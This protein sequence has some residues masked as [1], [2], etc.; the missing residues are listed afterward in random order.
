MPF[1]LKLALRYLFS[2][3]KGLVR[4]TSLIAI[5]GI[6]VGVA[7]LIIAQAVAT[8]FR[9][10]MQDK[11]LKNTA[12]ITIL[13]EGELKISNWNI[14]KRK[15]EEIENVEE[16]IPTSYESSVVSSDGISS[17]A[18]I[19]VLP[20]KDLQGNV[21][22][23]KAGTTEISVSIG[24]ELLEKLKLKVGDKADLL[25]LGK[26][27]TPKSSEVYV[28]NVLETGLYEYD[29]TWIHISQQHYLKLKDLNV[30]SPTAF[31]VSLKDIFQSGKTVE[32]I[33]KA[34]GKNFK[35]IGWQ[36][37]NKPLF[38]ALSLERKV[39]LA[40]ILLI[41]FI[42][43]LN[44][45]TTLA[46]LVNERKFDI[47]VLRTCGARTKSLIAIFLFEGL[48][49]SLAGIFFGVCLGIG[50]CLLGN[51]FKV[52]HISKEVYSLNYIPFRIDISIIFQIILITFFLCLLAIAYPVLRVSKIKPLEN[53]RTR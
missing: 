17:Y 24:K 14:V 3:R 35:V 37:A 44:I 43:A 34:L 2:S 4:F 50:S 51:Y 53:L 29:S 36:E 32:R 9:D 49:M 28:G 41:I 40:I 33:E 5:L 45:T 22:K 15:V 7:G 38:A 23:S 25:I 8:G 19:R 20:N 1:E 11:L 42:A 48:I 26:K 52:I 27:E 10:E 6:A 18:V 39:A 12:H 21:S 31:S 16:V 30:F 46:L 13:E 47:S